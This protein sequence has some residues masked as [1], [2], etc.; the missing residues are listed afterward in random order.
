V[1]LSITQRITGGEQSQGYLLS[2][3]EMSHTTLPVSATHERTTQA[4]RRHY[5]VAKEAGRHTDPATFAAAASQAAAG[6]N[7]SILSAHT[8]NEIICVVSVAAATGPQAVAVALAIVADALSAGDR[9]PSPRPRCRYLRCRVRSVA[10]SGSFPPAGLFAAGM[11]GDGLAVRASRL[12]GTISAVMGGSGGC[13]LMAI[14][15]WAER[16]GPLPGRG[17]VPV[18]G[19]G[20]AVMP[21]AGGGPS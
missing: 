14:S 10:D 12:P 13:A 3:P 21:A 19:P 8:A 18:A 17:G 9:L 20:G 16:S 15:C 1:N 2:R 11:A 7:A 5:P 6:R 4:S